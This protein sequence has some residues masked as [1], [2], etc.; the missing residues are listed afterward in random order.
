MGVEERTFLDIDSIIVI[1]GIQRP[2]ISIYPSAW[3]VCTVPLSED[4]SRLGGTHRITD[5]LEAA[6]Q[7][8]MHFNS[9][10]KGLLN[11]MSCVMASCPTTLHRDSFTA[12]SPLQ[13]LRNY[14]SVPRLTTDP[15][16]F[17]LITAKVRLGTRHCLQFLH[18]QPVLPLIDFCPCS[19]ISCLDLKQTTNDDDN[20]L[21][22]LIRTH[23]MALEFPFLLKLSP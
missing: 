17:N 18:R 23:L 10:T 15:D 20:C 6:A 21:A 22:I 11:V 5:Q 2:S 19:L 4:R 13:S 8:Q 14:S 9:P 12:P 1:P 3:F 7:H 16:C